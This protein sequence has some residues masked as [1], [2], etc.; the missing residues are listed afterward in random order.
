M[1][2]EHYFWYSYCNAT[3]PFQKG[4]LQREVA[5]SDVSKGLSTYHSQIETVHCAAHI[6]L[7]LLTTG[8]PPTK[9]QLIPLDTLP[10]S[11]MYN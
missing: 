4:Q 6:F 9:Q 8:P 7:K 5:I 10:L 11:S 3:V 1:P 2:I